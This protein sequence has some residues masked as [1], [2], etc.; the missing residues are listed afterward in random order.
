MILWGPSQLHAPSKMD[1]VHLVLQISVLG[2]SLFIGAISFRAWRYPLK[3][4]SVFIYSRQLC[5][6]TEPIYMLLG[7]H[8]KTC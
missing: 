1:V 2:F 6:C 3:E 4:N 7:K 8:I 5:N